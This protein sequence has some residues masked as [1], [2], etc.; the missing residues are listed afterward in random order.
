MQTF[1]DVLKK[2]LAFDV[3]QLMRVF[4]AIGLFSNGINS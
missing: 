1:A 3:K 2:K 4:D